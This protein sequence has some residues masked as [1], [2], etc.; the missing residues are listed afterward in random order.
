MVI[1]RSYGH[2]LY[3]NY[4]AEYVSPKKKNP[5]PPQISREGT[6]QKHMSF[7]LGLRDRSMEMCRGYQIY[8]FARE[9]NVDPPKLRGKKRR[10]P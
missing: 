7:F 4:Y 10:P 5:P 3:N 8:I 1:H 2:S 9:K 6:D